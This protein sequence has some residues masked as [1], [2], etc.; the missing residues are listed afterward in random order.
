ME[1]GS[2]ISNTNSEAIFHQE[3]SECPGNEAAE[4]LAEIWKPEPKVGKM[5]QEHGL[6]K[7]QP[8]SP[9]LCSVPHTCFLI[10]VTTTPS[11][12]YCYPCFTDAE[13]EAQRG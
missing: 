3:K 8:M 4:K 1:S 9:A 13:A 2:D 10:P 5:V 12:M 7:P 6:W 11:S